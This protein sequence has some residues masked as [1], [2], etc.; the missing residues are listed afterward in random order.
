MAKK[1]IRDINEFEDFAKEQSSYLLIKHSLTCPISQGAFE[2][3]ENFMEDHPD[4]EAYFLYVQDA[5]PLSNHIAEKFGVKHESPQVF[6][7]K[8]N[9]VAWHASHW[10]ITYDALTKAVQ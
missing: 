3:F 1:N 8:D 6:F 4:V 2:E 7:I 5:R 10:N 9:K